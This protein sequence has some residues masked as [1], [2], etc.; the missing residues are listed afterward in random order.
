MVRKRG[1]IGKFTFMLVFLLLF[2]SSARLLA[3][4]EET[5]KSDYTELSLEELMEVEIV[6]SAT[7]TGT[8]PR[9]VPSAVTTITKKDIWSSGARSLYELLDIYV[10]NLQWSRHHWENDVLGLRGI[11]TDRNYQYLL[12]VNGRVM[13][14]RT[15]Y[16]ALSELD[17]VMLSDI[18]HI[19]VVRG[20]GSALY[21][22]GAVSM[23][24]NIITYDSDTFQGTEIT[25]RLG[26]VEEFYSGEIKHGRKFEDGD[27]GLFFSGGTANY[28]GASKYDAPQIY[29]FDFPR[30]GGTPPPGTIPGEGTEAGSPL[31]NTFLNRDGA[32]ALDTM[33]IKGH[34]QIKRGG[35]DFW[36]RYTRGGKHFAW[37]TGSIARTPFGWGDWAWYTRGGYNGHPT[38]YRANWYLYQQLTGY[39][40]RTQQLTENLDLDYAFSYQTTSV[41]KEREVRPVDHYREDNYYGKILLKWRPNE[42]HKVAVGGEALYY[43]IGMKPWEGWGYEPGSI[44]GTVP[45]RNPHAQPAAWPYNQL[46]PRWKSHMHSVLGEWQWNINDQWTTFLGGRIDDHKY[47]RPMY[48][49][50]AVLVHTPNKRDTYKLMWG[51]SV[52]ANTEEEMKL[53]D[54]AGGGTCDSEKFDS[55]ELRY[56][57]MH[58]ENLDLAASVYVH[59]N[60]QAIVWNENIDVSGLAGTQ[61]EYGIELE[62]DY[63]TD[64]TRIHASHGYT[65]LYSF[66]L[67]Q[68]RWT[69]RPTAPSQAVTAEPYGYGHDLTNW[70]NHISKLT[71][72][73]KLDDKWTFDASLRIYW[74]FPGMKDFDSYFPYAGGNR[75]SIIEGGWRR[76]YRGSYFLNL[77]LQ[78]KHSKNLE[79]NLTG[80]NLLG[81]FNKDFNKRNYV[82]T[83]GGG[84]FRSHAPAIGVSML[85]KF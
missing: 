75:P 51:R 81:V 55:V 34:L 54:D 48:S 67:E 58:N 14:Q 39:I 85:Y 68:D 7:L 65:K 9:L 71:V 44:S 72:Q 78:Y 64:K 69:W 13:N 45:I 63:H 52:R 62:A 22:P 76:A 56:E 43:D 33:P 29:P 59:Y 37:H 18:H 84:D 25:G 11:I 35:W 31:T 73:H 24:I 79:V 49:P 47:T 15:H 77:G 3:E 41:A 66:Y 23:V 61:R 38:Y 28:V 20:P 36:V 4:Q 42:K 74:G 50:R 32:A 30:S 53:Q 21:G 26:A 5:T 27:G 1:L 10:P 8:K 17:L 19:D 82:Q 12:L 16:G 80:Y 40:G 70:S 60:L 46:M 83:A 2:A 57:R 6:S